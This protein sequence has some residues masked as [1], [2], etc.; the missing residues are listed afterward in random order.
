MKNNEHNFDEESNLPLGENGKNPFRLP[1]DY[2]ASFE[3]KLKKKLELENE[4]SEFSLLSSL[5]KI[6]SFSTPENYFSSNE[7]QIE[8]SAYPK[9]QAINKPV[10]ADLDEQY[11]TQ[12][13]ASVS[14]KIEL[15][16]EL[17]T[18]SLLYQLDKHNPFIVADNYFENLPLQIKERIHTS[19]QEK[20]GVLDK[21][22]GFIFGRKLALAFGLAAIVVVSLYLYNASNKVMND[23]DCH[24]MA[25]LEKQ[26]VLNEKNI[27]NFDDEQL[28]ELVDVNTLD[29]QLNAEIQQTDTLQNEEF[30]LENTNTDQLLEELQ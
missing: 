24:T 26:D 19:A 10:V 11:T 16:E 21:V 9:L 28:M 6:N 14:Y 13:Q 2:F 8:L 30:I 15:T 27:Q 23:S 7:T 12:L 20:L 18:Y 22:L 29:K 5:S 4:L 3:D 25:C 1:A 17:K